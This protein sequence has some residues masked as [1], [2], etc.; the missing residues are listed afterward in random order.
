MEHASPKVLFNV[1][2]NVFTLHNLSYPGAVLGNSVLGSDTCRFS[3]I[4]LN[5]FNVITSLITGF[6]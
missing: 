3:I 6:E 2:T 4:F 1:F 5:L